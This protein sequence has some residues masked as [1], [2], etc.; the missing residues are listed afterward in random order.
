[1]HV[2]CWQGLPCTCRSADSCWYNL[3][4]P[5]L[6]VG[7]HVLF[8]W[9]LA[10]GSYPGIRYQWATLVVSERVYVYPTPFQGQGRNF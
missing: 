9:R 3:V 7:V 5:R 2:G 10:V 1:M 8:E 4:Q 6:P